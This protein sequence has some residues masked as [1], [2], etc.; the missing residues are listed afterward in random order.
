M[1]SF[2]ALFFFAIILITS[3]LDIIILYICINVN[4][5]L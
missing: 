2:I 4:P 3:Y 1:I 5:F